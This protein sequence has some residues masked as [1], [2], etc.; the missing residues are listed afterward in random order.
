MYY[1]QKDNTNKVVPYTSFSDY[2]EQ[3]RQAITPWFVSQASISTSSIDMKRL[4]RFHTI[5]DGNNANTL[6]KVSISNILPDEGTFDVLIRDFYDTDASPII[7]ES[8]KGV[9]LLKGSDKYL[10]LKVGD[11]EEFAL[12][13]KYVMVEINE[14]SVIE[15]MV[16]CGFLGYPIR[17][18]GKTTIHVQYNL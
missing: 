1:M 13:S 15:G 18:Y 4:F 6:I 3:F 17:N 12:K 5:S 14:D 10:G 8:Y 11:G 16:P 9:N 2:R 7:L